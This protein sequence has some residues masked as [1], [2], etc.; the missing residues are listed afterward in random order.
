MGLQIKENNCFKCVKFDQGPEE[1]DG[2][3][4]PPI[5]RKGWLC[6][7]YVEKGAPCPKCEEVDNRIDE[8]LGESRQIMSRQHDALGESRQEIEELKARNG[9]LVAE[10]STLSTQCSKLIDEKE[11]LV[12]RAKVAK[13][14]EVCNFCKYKPGY[15]CCYTCGQDRK[16]F[17]LEK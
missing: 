12:K 1:C 3:Y 13:A 16:N 7:G 5:L 9:E 14:I 11:K 17:R 6:K 10:N 2:K 4:V 15:G 8:K